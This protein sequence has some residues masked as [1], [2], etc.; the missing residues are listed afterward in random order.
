MSQML[1][2]TGYY[3]QMDRT[4]MVILGS[5]FGVAL[6][7][8]FVTFLLCIAAVRKKKRQK[9]QHFSRLVSDLNATEKF[10]IANDSDDDEEYEEIS[11]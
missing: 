1:L 3:Y 7:S 11:E 6:F 5:V 2:Q 4:N 10:S 9:K 8:F